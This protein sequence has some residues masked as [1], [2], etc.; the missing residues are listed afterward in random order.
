MTDIEN[1]ITDN[2]SVNA[3]EVEPLLGNGSESAELLKNVDDEEGDV[4]DPHIR[5]GDEATVN[6]LGSMVFVVNQIYGI[7]LLALPLVFQQ[8][9]FDN[10]AFAF[11]SLFLI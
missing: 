1:P 6:Y 7:G 4:D 8:G 5:T 2:H 3:T 9:N 11:F 10:S